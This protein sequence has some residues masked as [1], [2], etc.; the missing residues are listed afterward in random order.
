[1]ADGALS[2]YSWVRRGLATT[3]ATGPL[4]PRTIA[5]VGLG[6][7][8]DPQLVVTPQLEL[9]GP[10]DI[11][12]LDANVVVRTWPKAEDLD[13]EF[14]SY[15]LIEFDQADLLWRYSPAPASEQ[16][17]PWLS[18]VVLA[19]GEGSIAPATPEQKLAVLTVNDVSDLPN[20][21]D[22][23]AWAHTQFAGQNLSEQAIKDQLVGQPGLFTGRVMSPRLLQ[24][25]TEYIACLVPTFE[26]GRQIGLGKLQPNGTDPK[27][28]PPTLDRWD[29]TDT[30]DG[31][32]KLP[33]YYSWRFRTGSIGNFEQA[34]RLIKPFI[35]PETMGRR[36]MDVSAPGLD[37]LPASLA[38]LPAE[39]A[40]MSVAASEAE[41]PVWPEPGRQAFIDDLA[42]LLNIPADGDVAELVP[43]L[44]G[45]WYAADN[46][47]DPLP[48]GSNPVWFREL[49]SDPRNR[50][51]SAL[52]TQ[53]IQ[54]EQQALLASGWDQVGEIQN[55]NDQARVLQLARGLLDRI[56]IRHFT[57]ASLQRFYHLTFRLHAWVT[58]G[59][60][61]VC[62][63]VNDSPILPGFLSAQWLRWTRP[64]GPIGL[65]QGRPALTTFVPNL[66]TKLNACRVPATEPPVPPGIHDPKNPRDGLYCESIETLIGLGSSVTLFWGLTLLW[67]VRKLLVTQNGDCWWLALKA[68][69]YAI[70][71]IRISISADDVRRRCRLLTGTFTPQD[72]LNAPPLQGF[73]LP[74]VVLPATIPLPAIPTGA[75]TSDSPDAVALR[76]AL[77]RFQQAF[78][79]PPAL[80]CRPGMELEQCRATLVTQ[81]RP[82]LT[83]GEVFLVRRH[84]TVDW[85][86]TDRLEPVFAAPE[87]ERPMYLP[88][89]AISSDWILPGLNGMKRDSIGLAVTNQR[90]IEAYMAGLNHEMTR[91]LLWNEF[92]TDQRG[93]YFRQ[94]WDTAGHILENGSK[95][96][97][98]QLRDINPMRLWPEDA[99]LGGNSPRPPAGSGGE[100]FLVLVVRAQ[101]IQKYPNVIVY[102]QQREQSTGRLTGKQR[103][104]IFYALLAP[105]TAFYGFDITAE[106]VR[107]DPSLYF[108]L[109]EQPG[110]PKF[111]DEDTN[112]DND[113]YTNPASPVNRGT[114]AGLVA[115]NTFHQPFRLGIQGTT[116]LPEPPPAP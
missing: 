95:L 112:R 78:V 36:D 113:K 9:V 15:A 38:S 35:L 56:W 111:A 102:I 63:N 33:V 88:L 40:L 59:S 80:T 44:Y 34:A 89:S 92:P 47:L 115:Q 2:F 55:I 93:T 50:V 85:E 21:D 10:G 108:V 41:P 25:N 77:F 82:E 94:F 57:T 100:P 27:F 11:V 14:V 104:P 106:Q 73:T 71:L 65:L 101:L 91:E 87:Y 29:E 60:K 99:P 3:V 97:P 17:L 28:N 103:H 70:I 23:W 75:G 13:A 83:V 67:V 16:V 26:R 98:D 20:L 24:A 51:A 39:G 116:L 110:E 52:G 62:G 53:V 64:H 4:A 1:V 31:G 74:A 90:F 72:I 46:R 42:A 76:D 48:S 84:V 66:I 18:L 12:G 22:L 109:Q 5:T 114:N 30:A 105:D 81:L 45:Q 54:R 8:G 68:L 69:R 32:F 19:A 7:N 49:N 37:L 61:T 43:P 96:P 107:D 86:P 6:F 58:C 79:L